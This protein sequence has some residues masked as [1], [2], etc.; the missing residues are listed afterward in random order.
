MPGDTPPELH[1]DL[2]PV[3]FLLGGWHGNG[4]GDYPTIDRFEF[5]QEAAFTHD[6]RPFLYYVSRSWEL[7]SDGQPARPRGMESGFLRMQPVGDVEFLLAHATGYVELYY[8]RV[9]GA[10]IELATDAVVRSTSAKDYT[11]G[12]RLYGVVDGDLLWTY[13][14]AAVGQPLQSH[15]WA[16]LRRD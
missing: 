9:E 7:D 3:G 8:G 12:H 11:A 14:M 6:G 16:R 10:K 4:H 5:Q 2:L 15:L 13:D 1:P